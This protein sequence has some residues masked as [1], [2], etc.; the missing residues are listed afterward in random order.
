MF[1]SIRTHFDMNGIVLV[2]VVLNKTLKQTLVFIT[3][4]G[5]SDS[6]PTVVMTVQIPMEWLSLLEIPNL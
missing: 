6:D 1:C 4:T 3:H 5:F 2:Y